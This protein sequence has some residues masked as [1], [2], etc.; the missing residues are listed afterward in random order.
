MADAEH[1]VCDVRQWSGTFV[2][3]LNVIVILDTLIEQF[4]KIAKRHCQHLR[5]QFRF[6]IFQIV[7]DAI[8][9][10]FLLEIDVAQHALQ[11]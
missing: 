10:L 3:V 6:D 9:F 4:H 5:R 11:F 2:D 8:P 1:C 7:S